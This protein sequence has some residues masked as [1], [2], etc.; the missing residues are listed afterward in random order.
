M[1]P[2]S[3]LI[4]GVRFM[5][6]KTMASCSPRHPLQV[7][8]SLLTRKVSLW[9]GARTR[10]WTVFPSWG[11]PVASWLSTGSVKVVA[12]LALARV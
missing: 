8:K 10:V 11:V 12:P 1:F 9:A 7:L 6:L 3:V 2:P 5:L 4:R